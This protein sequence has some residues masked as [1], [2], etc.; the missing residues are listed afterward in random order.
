MIYKLKGLNSLCLEF[1]NLEKADKEFMDHSIH[2]IKILSGLEALR[3][4]KIC[5]PFQKFAFPV[6]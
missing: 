2:I 6:L 1:C 3:V 4:I 5:V